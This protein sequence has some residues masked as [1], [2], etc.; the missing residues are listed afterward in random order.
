MVQCLLEGQQLHRRELKDLRY[1]RLGGA[2]N[3]PCGCDIAGHCRRGGCLLGLVG[4][5][6]R[7][8]AVQV[9]PATP[10]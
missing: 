2:G 8:D 10:G 7:H 1:N 4:L 9:S 3:V 6:M 5:R